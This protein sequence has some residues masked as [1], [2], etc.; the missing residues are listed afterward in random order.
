MTV[1]QSQRPASLPQLLVIVITLLFSS[2]PSV[3]WRCWLGGGKG[4]QP[5]KKLEWWGTGV[6]ICLERDG[7]MHMA[8]LMPLPLTVFCF[9]KIQIGFT[10]LILAH[11]GSFGER[12]VKQV[13]V[14]VCYVFWCHCLPET[15]T[16]LASFKSRLVLPFWYRLT[17]VVLEK[18][19]LN[20]CSVGVVVLFCSTGKVMAPCGL[21]GVVE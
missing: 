8:Q 12:V 4:I 10:F 15:P 13:C 11:P 21:G 18:R 17:Q 7:D 2:I 14:Y 16:S 19:P 20:G 1:E 6:V 5:V 3:L 9:S